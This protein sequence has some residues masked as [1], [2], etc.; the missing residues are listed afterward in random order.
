MPCSPYGTRTVSTVTSRDQGSELP[1]ATM[2]PQMTV[3][4][5]LTRSEDWLSLKPGDAVGDCHARRLPSVHE[6]QRLCADKDTGVQNTVENT[7]SQSPL[8]YHPRPSVNGHSGNCRRLTAVTPLTAV[9]YLRT[10]GGSATHQNSDAK[11]PPPPREDRPGP[12]G[13]LNWTRAQCPPRRP[14]SGRR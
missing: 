6:A 13:G 9:G 10:G 1:G 8:A 7:G 5:D 12:G 14:C 4:A 2:I 3:V 11:P